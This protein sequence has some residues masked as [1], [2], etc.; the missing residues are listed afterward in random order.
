MTYPSTQRTKKREKMKKARKTNGC[1]LA[2]QKPQKRRRA[3]H[4]PPSDIKHLNL[5]IVHHHQVAD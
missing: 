2:E 5:H 1:K 4:N 3:T